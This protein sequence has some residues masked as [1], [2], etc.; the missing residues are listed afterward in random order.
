MGKSENHFFVVGREKQHP[1]IARRARKFDNPK[2]RLFLNNFYLSKTLIFAKTP[3]FRRP[4]FLQKM[5]FLTFFRKIFRGHF[6]MPFPIEF[7]LLTPSKSF[8]TQKTRFLKFVFLELYRI[9]QKLGVLKVP[10]DLRKNPKSWHSKS[11][12]QN[13]LFKNPLLCTLRKRRCFW[14]NK[15]GQMSWLLDVKWP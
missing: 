5:R 2:K 9:L 13:G 7:Y 3:I 8:L 15:G 10:T 1:A 11:E 12:I 4:P 6:S 14:K